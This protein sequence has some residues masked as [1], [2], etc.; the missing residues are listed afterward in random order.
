M[1]GPCYLVNLFSKFSHDQLQQI[2]ITNVPAACRACKTQ[3]CE[4]KLHLVP[5]LA[6]K[7]LAKVLIRTIE[8][9]EIH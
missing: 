2:A 6:V 9:L 5:Y 8:K 1:H 3:P 4:C 7:S